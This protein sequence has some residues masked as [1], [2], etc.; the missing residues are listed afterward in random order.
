MR[1]VFIHVCL[2]RNG[3]NLVFFF[4]QAEDGIRDVAVTGVQTCALPISSIC[5][6]CSKKRW[7]KSRVTVE[8]DRVTLDCA[9]KACSIENGALGKPAL[10]ASVTTGVIPGAVTPPH[11]RGRLGR[12]EP[13]RSTWG[14]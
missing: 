4:F 1:V 2:R 11:V 10:R 3:A 5:I 12:T 8:V 7:T 14:I 6:W 13:L 9:A